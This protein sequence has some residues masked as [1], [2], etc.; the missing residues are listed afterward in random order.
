VLTRA[1]LGERERAREKGREIE[2]QQKPPVRYL[3]VPFLCNSQWS[4]IANR[5]VRKFLYLLSLFLIY[6]IFVFGNFMFGWFGIEID[7]FGD[8][9]GCSE[10]RFKVLIIGVSNYLSPEF[11]VLSWAVFGCREKY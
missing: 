7:C 3:Y 4:P 10:I 8:S 6:Y 2:R 1:A 5:L 11:L 9:V